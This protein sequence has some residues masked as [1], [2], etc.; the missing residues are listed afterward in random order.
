MDAI[1]AKAIRFYASENSKAAA[2]YRVRAPSVRPR[3][4]TIIESEAA[5]IKAVGAKPRTGNNSSID[6]ARSAREI[7]HFL[8]W[9]AKPRSIT[10]EGVFR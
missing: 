9:R 8:G 2:G 5:K 6:S 7:A 1:V 10:E 4:F 3:I